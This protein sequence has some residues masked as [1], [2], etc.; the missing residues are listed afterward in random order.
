MDQE[1]AG[2][3]PSDSGVAIGQLI[4]K[5]RVASVLGH[6]GM[7]TVY[8]AV[9]EQIGKHA[10]I[11]V[12]HPQYSQNPEMATR[13][14]NEARAVNL[15]QH[16]GIINIF[17]FG[18]LDNGA[19][20]IAMDFL[21][22]VPLHMRLQQPVEARDALRI[23]REIAMALKAAHE[24]GIVHRDLK[25]Q[26][27]MIVRDPAMPDQERVKV[28]DFG[29]A[30]LQAQEGPGAPAH[31]STQAGAVMGT[32]AYMAP[33]Q[34][35]GAKSVTDRADVYA[36]GVILFQMLAGRPPFT[37]TQGWELMSMHVSAS[38]PPLRELCPF[39]A[40]DLATLTHAMLT[41]EPERRPTMAEVAAELLKLLGAD[42]GAPT[43]S[44]PLALANVDASAP[45]PDHLPQRA[46][47][48]P[49]LRHPRGRRALYLG[50]LLLCGL[51]LAG[52]ALARWLPD[53]HAPSPTAVP[54]AASASP[55]PDST[56]AAVPPLAGPV[57]KETA[58]VSAWGKGSTGPEV[59]VTPETPTPATRA[60]KKPPPRKTR[61]NQD[62]PLLN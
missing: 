31:L 4:G 7:G 25:P 45:T 57:P 26:N 5:Y 23:C 10:A 15:I 35:L 48:T 28:L 6:G 13:F 60:E 1:P 21:D 36:L 24:R 42:R 51:L 49:A 59:R 44:R 47:E 18:K 3:N 46:A 16:P 20:Y 32:P 14:L 37:A 34:C 8:L 53:R 11:K 43:P 19:S 40:P 9:H 52:L 29:I 2:A 22:G 12:L 54:A 58:F 33:E 50:G 17:E 55:S 30:K 39:L 56:S 41:K 38:P 62:I 61:R 27:I